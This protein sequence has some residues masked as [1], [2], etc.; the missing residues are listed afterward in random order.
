MPKIHDETLG[1][2]EEVPDEM[3]MEPSSSAPAPPPP[4]PTY[5]AQP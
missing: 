4:A 5:P 2:E 1:E 3:P